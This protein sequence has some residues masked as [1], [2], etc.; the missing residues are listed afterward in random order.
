M[1]IMGINRLAKGIL[2]GIY[3]TTTEFLSLKLSKMQ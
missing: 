2:D 1:D 3:S